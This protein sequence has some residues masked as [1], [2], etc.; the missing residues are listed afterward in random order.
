M[1]AFYVPEEFEITLK[2]LKEILKRE[3]KSLSEWI[4]EN[5]ER[6]VAVHAH[7]NP[8]LRIDKFTGEVKEKVCFFCQ[9]RFP[10]LYRVRYVSGLVAPTCQTCLDKNKAKGQFSTVKK[11]L[12]L[13]Q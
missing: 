10:Q 9:G 4:R 8:Q 6:Y 1:D 2:E 3:G 13:V 11:V 12:G 5:A 7:G